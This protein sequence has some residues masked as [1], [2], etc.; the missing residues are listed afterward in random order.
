M[1]HKWNWA[2]AGA[3]PKRDYGV[4]DFGMDHDIQDSIK[5]LNQNEKRYGQWTLPKDDWYLQTEENVD[6]EPL[7]TWAP[8]PKKGHKVD[9]FVPNFG[10]DEDVITTKTNIKNLDVKFPSFVQLDESV[11][12]EPLL[13]WAPSDK[14]GFKKN[15]FVPNFGE[16]ENVVSTQQNVNAAEVSTGH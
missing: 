4:P 1:G 12:R 13:S 3:P 10:L 14:K 7:A 5:H 11:E 2:K 16:D 6:R 9:Y 8:T 15:Y